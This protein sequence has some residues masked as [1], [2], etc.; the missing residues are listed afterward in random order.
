MEKH[1]N[2]L[3]GA[4]GYPDNK[5]PQNEKQMTEYCRLVMLPL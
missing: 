4:F 3:F 2:S 5:W 1:F